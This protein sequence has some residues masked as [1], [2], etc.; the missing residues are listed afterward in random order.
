MSL[1]EEVCYSRVGFEASKLLPVEL[2]LSVLDLL[3]NV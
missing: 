1:L 2:V 3:L